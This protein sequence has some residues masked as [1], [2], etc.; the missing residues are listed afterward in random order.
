MIMKNTKIPNG[1]VYVNT[2]GIGMY[3]AD[4]LGSIGIKVTRISSLKELL[5]RKP[6]DCGQ[7]V[8]R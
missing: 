2:T 4:T 3:I 5:Q 7:H 1:Y 8:N 6:K